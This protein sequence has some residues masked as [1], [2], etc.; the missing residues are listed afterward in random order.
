MDVGELIMKY[1]LFFIVSFLM[2][3]TVSQ[4]RPPLAYQI[5]CL[6]NTEECLPDSRR[7]VSFNKS[8]VSKLDKINRKVNTTI[9]PVNEDNDVW[10]I[11]VSSGDCEDYALTKRSSLIK[12]GV[13]A[14]ALRMAVVLTSDNVGHA[15]L[16]VMTDKGQLILD[17]LH[18]K[19]K[20]RQHT[21]YTYLSIA[22]NDPLRWINF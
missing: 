6:Q 10:S 17:N 5:F 7:I 16:I 2:M 20:F 12:S 9:K 13:P 3:I 4:A 11:N 15:V 22:S 18:N 8:L 1:I 19:V 14:G 21:N